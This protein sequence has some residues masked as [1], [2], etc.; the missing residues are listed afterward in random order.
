[1]SLEYPMVEAESET[2]R[3]QSTNDYYVAGLLIIKPPVS[4][5]ALYIIDKL[6]K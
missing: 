2:Q 3:A 1:M 5:C 4:S 6:N